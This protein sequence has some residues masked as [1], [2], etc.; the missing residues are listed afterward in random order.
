M[1][2]KHNL[3]CKSI[4]SLLKFV[5][6]TQRIQ[7]RNGQY[8]NVLFIIPFIIDV[9]GHRFE[10]FTLVSEIYENVHWVFGIK[11]YLS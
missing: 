8:V 6:K 11:T 2:K 5:P 9:Y 4:H 1:S 10:I 7:V 3:R